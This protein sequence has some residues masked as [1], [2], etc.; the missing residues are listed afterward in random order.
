MFLFLSYLAF[1]MSHNNFCPSHHTSHINPLLPSPED[2]GQ[3][4][5]SLLVTFG[6]MQGVGRSRIVSYC[7]IALPKMMGS[8]KMGTPKCSF[9]V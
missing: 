2:V 1:Y 4:C 7:F 9:N 6:M 8:A 5:G 3:K